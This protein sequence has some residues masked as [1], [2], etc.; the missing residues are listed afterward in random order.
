MRPLTHNPFPIHHV[1][2]LHRFACQQART[3]EEERQRKT[4]NRK[5][6]RSHTTYFQI[7][8]HHTFAPFRLPA[9]MSD[10]KKER[11]KCALSLATHTYIKRINS[12]RKRNS[13]DEAET[14]QNFTRACRTAH[15]LRIVSI[16]VC[17][18]LRN[19]QY[20]TFVFR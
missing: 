3:M 19:S 2:R 12:L 9:S 16:I 20:F 11:R 8:I 17:R 10:R 14:N 6:A 18:L 13:C 7:P 1:I 5:C 15:T 4:E